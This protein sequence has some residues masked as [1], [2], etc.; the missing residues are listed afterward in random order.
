V[1][2]SGV[3]AGPARVPADPAAPVAPPSG[4]SVTTVALP[5]PTVE[6]VRGLVGPERVAA[7]VAAAADREV[8]ARRMDALAAA[9]GEQAPVAPDPH[10][11]GSGPA[12]RP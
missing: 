8:A 10:G 6:A 1:A 11:P 12:V 9:E 4:A 5:A 3:P 7:F 2:G